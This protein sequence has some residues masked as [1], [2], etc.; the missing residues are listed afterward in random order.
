MGVV[1]AVLLSSLYVILLYEEMNE[2]VQL[3]LLDWF[4]NLG[5]FRVNSVCKSVVLLCCYIV[6]STCNVPF[7]DCPRICPKFKNQNETKNI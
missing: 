7:L 1:V 3:P 2:A 6:A 5:G 4:H